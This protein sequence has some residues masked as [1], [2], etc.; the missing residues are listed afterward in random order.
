MTAGMRVLMH[1]SSTAN[2][3]LSTHRL[4]L[5]L[6]EFK[7]LCCDFG[8]YDPDVEFALGGATAHSV[9]SKRQ[10]ALPQCDA[11]MIKRN[12]H[13]PGSPAS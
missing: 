5:T 6:L 13:S 11:N 1:H 7:H 2:K 3:P 10:Q 8:M 4:G 9:Y 12:R